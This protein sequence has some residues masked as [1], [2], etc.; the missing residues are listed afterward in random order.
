M[1]SP[2]R[3]FGPADENDLLPSSGDLTLGLGPNLKLA[4]RSCGGLRLGAYW[5]A[6]VGD[7]T[8]VL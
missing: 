2:D 7:L 3:H 1:A 5:W 4:N 8:V 6:T